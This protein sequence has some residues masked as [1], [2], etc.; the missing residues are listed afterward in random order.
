MTSEVLLP[1]MVYI[2]GSEMTPSEVF[3]TA[4]TGFSLSQAE[5]LSKSRSE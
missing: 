5:Y 2:G 1:N 3:Y 4:P